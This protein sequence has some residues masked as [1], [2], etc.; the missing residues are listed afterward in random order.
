MKRV[1][2]CSNPYR[3]KNFRTARQAQKI[4]NEVSIE[5]I[6][7][8]AFDVDKSTELPKDIHFHDMKRNFPSQIC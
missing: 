1:V 8:L 7:C 3:D 5:A 2:L 4:L 6:M